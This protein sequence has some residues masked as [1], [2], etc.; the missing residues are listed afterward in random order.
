MALT[1]E[2]MQELQVN[3]LDI[4]KESDAG[5]DYT[6]PR[7]N[8]KYRL[9]NEVNETT[10][11]IA[12]AP[13]DK[14]GKPDYSQ[15]TIVVAGTQAPGGDI[16][17]HVLESGFNAVMARNQ[18]TEQTKDVREFYN[19]SLSKAKKMAGKGQ[20]V[21]ISNMSGFSQAGP[22]V[23]K[24]AAEM[25][26]KKIT[27]F[28]D[29]GAWN[30]LTKNTADYRGISDEEFNY[31]NKHLHSYS[32]RGKD[33]TSW[34]GH[35][36]IIPYGKVF[37]VEGKHHNAGLPKIKGNSLDIKW[38]V[39]NSLFCSGMTEMQVREIAK[40]KAKAA[41]KFDLSKLET[42]FDSTDP[43]SYVKEYVEKYGSFAPEPSKQELLTLKRRRIDELHASLK[44]TTGSQMIS[45]REELV[46]TSAQT[47]QLQ[48]EV[49]EQTIKDKLANAKE[50]VSQ[51]ITELRS[52][53]YT[54][55]HNL[56]S[57]EIEDL[58]SELSFELAWNTGIEAATLS[59]ANSYQK[60]M[61][62]IAGKLNKA[63]DRIVEID[64]KGSQIFGE[65]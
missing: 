15:T 13:L 14:E 17:N 20:E 46:R 53:A 37:T 16:N 18:L 9:I 43:E 51:H 55:A 54:L 41:E 5:K 49:Y 28:M 21:D 30:S 34:D 58:L 3:V 25:K 19:Q 29:W 8:H 42:W 52:A 39:K 7:T 59:S 65:L 45:L 56:S 61:T 64:Q 36:G 1:D 57:G 40:R 27:N 23:A 47:A 33:L 60:K 2:K 10:Q 31:L 12:V 22:A 24:V 6:I 38:Y 63:A 62:S 26:V 32:D 50:S 4:I 48:A 35:G 44:T 11:A